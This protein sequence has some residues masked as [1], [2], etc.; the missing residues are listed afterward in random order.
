MNILETLI[1]YIS[2]DPDNTNSSPNFDNFYIV[3]EYLKNIT[4]L[5]S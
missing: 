5:L 2:P 1:L 3:S 4:I